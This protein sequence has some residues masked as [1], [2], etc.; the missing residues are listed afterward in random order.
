MNI[1]LTPIFE[2]VI[3]LLAA[4]I[5]YKVIPWIKSRTT[6]A[7]QENLNA[8]VKTLVYAAEQLYGAN[9]GKEKLAY[10]KGK[11]AEKG[12]DVDVDAIE[13]AVARYLNVSPE[14]TLYTNGE[15]ING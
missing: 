9:H 7:Q 11:L 12:Y 4:F 10:V 3:A 1:N 13:A 2:A 6:L 5:T 15:E 14:I 8:M